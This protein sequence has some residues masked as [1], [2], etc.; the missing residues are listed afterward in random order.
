MRPLGPIS[1]VEVRE[2]LWHTGETSKIGRKSVAEEDQKQPEAGQEQEPAAQ[3][4][5]EPVQA[6]SEE[7]VPRVRRRR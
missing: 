7:Q 4:A 1:D 5:P 3:E 6:E 2:V